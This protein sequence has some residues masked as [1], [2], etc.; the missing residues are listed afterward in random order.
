[1]HGDVAG[2]TAEHALEHGGHDRP[3]VFAFMVFALTLGMLM[4]KVLPMIEV[5]NL[6]Y[7]VVMFILG[8]ILGVL[9]Y[10]ELVPLGSLAKGIDM[11]SNIDPHLLLYIFLPCLLFGDSMGLSW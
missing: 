2:H 11:W 3:A 10:R 9:H 1:M 8:G 4:F 5:V 6:P 7:T